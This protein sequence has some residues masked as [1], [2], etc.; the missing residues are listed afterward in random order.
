[1]R[2]ISI[3]KIQH[4]Y[5]RANLLLLEPY[6]NQRTKHKT[7]CL[8]CNYVWWITPHNVFRG[9]GCAGKCLAERRGRNLLA[10]STVI[11]AYRRK[12]LKL[13]E[14]YRGTKYPHKTRCLICNHVWNPKPLDVL[15]KSGCP[16]CAYVAKFGETNPNW[17]GGNTKET[18]KKRNSDLIKRL[19]ATPCTD[20]GIQ[21]PYYVMQF[22]HVKGKKKYSLSNLKCSACSVETI[23][24]EA[25]KCD[26]V[27]ANCHAIRTFKRG[28]KNQYGSTGVR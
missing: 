23:V 3:S 11:E 18:R 2:K 28:Y 27:C 17:R 9:Q 1:M 24:Q 4:R 12:N 26:V 6:V 25:K 16:K 14:P 13:V 22:D 20:C 10:E 7:K 19:K 5:Q 8:V 21:Y 15:H